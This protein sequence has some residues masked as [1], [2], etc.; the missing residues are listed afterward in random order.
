MNKNKI[1]HLVERDYVDQKSFLNLKLNMTNV[2]YGQI[3]PPFQGAHNRTPN[4][5]PKVIPWAE[6]SWAF[7]PMTNQK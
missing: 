1:Y 4:S 5:F 6:F 3:N 2:I 7:S